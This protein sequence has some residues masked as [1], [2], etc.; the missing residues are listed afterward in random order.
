[1]A[2][3]RNDRMAAALNRLAEGGTTAQAAEAAGVTTRTILQY[4]RDPDFLHRLR[5]ARGATN[6]MIVVALTHFALEAVER[7]H[8]VMNDPRSTQASVV[9]AAT[10]I[11][12]EARAHRDADIDA[13]LTELEAAARR[14]QLR[15]I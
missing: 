14:G 9:K 6:E 3:S 13:R 8:Q 1:M 7:L 2:R 12:A 5:E 15:V 11:L 4:L 10:S